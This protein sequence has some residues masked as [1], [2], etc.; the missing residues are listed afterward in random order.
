[1]TCESN[2]ETGE[3]NPRHL[4]SREISAAIVDKTREVWIAR[5]E[6][7]L[8]LE[9]K[10]TVGIGFAALTRGG[11]V[12]FEEDEDAGIRP[13]TVAEAEKLAQRAP[14][15]EWC[16]HL[17]GPGQE[18]H[19]KRVGEAQW[20]LYRWGAGLGR[21]ASRSVPRRRIPHEPLRGPAPEPSSRRN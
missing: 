16:I 7:L 17:V 3:A 12:I 13:M 15:H 11:W 4:D 8:P 2:S 19:Y 5:P 6:E 18:R 10:I 1:M 20:K 9:A 21:P 14:E